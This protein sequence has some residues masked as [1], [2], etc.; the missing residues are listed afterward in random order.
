MKKCLNG[1][2]CVLAIIV[3]V[4]LS[5]CAI[6]GVK[7]PAAPVTVCDQ[8]P[9]PSLIEQYIPD[10]RAAN[11]LLKLSV[12]EVSRLK[13]VQKQDIIKVLDEADAMLAASTT[14]QGLATYLLAK[15][16]F[17]QQNM[18]AEIMIAGDYLI[19]FQNTPTAISAK[20]VCYIKYQIADTR[21]KVLP[22]IPAK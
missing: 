15:V 22:W 14:Y 9:G 8:F 12:Y 20:D 17:I 5:G 11:M 19:S 2:M 3:A 18:G 7:A 4:A 10:L 1:K 21:A 13:A 6:T 16:K